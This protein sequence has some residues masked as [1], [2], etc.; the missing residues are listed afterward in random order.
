[1]ARRRHERV[2]GRRVVARDDTVQET[3]HRNTGFLAIAGAVVL[4]EALVRIE[5]LVSSVWAA[6]APG[7]RAAGSGS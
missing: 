4:G 5:A 7:M 1:M 6:R 2:A 3:L